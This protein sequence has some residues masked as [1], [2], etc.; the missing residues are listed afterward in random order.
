MLM[1][2]CY[3]LCSIVGLKENFICIVVS[4]VEWLEDSL[5]EGSVLVLVLGAILKQSTIGWSDIYQGLQEPMNIFRMNS[6]YY[7]GDVLS[8]SVFCAVDSY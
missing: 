4:D 6:W 8:V 7:S 2:V 3:S 1:R 5:C